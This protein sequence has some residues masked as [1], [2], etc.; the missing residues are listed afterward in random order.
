MLDRDLKS[1]AAS[2]DLAT[3][4]EASALHGGLGSARRPRLR[5]AGTKGP[6]LWGTTVD[7]KT[8]ASREAFLLHILFMYGRRGIAFHKINTYVWTNCYVHIGKKNKN[9]TN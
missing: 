9:T 2:G 3:R 8:S 7:N 1:T 4:R 6:T 5:A